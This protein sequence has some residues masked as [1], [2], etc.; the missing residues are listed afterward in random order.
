M[1]HLG[2]QS[3]RPPTGPTGDTLVGLAAVGL[4]GFVL[5]AVSEATGGKVALPCL[6]RTLTGLDCP[7]CGATRMAGALL[8]GDL[9]AAVQFNAPVLLAGV[10]TAYLWTGWVLERLGVVALPLPRLTPRRRRW[11]L[12]LSVAAAL[13]FMVVRNLPWAPFTDLRV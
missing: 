6:L 13:V 8:H 3:T 12:V 7:F 9:A 2:P 5:A 10:V 1:H 4:F 11:L